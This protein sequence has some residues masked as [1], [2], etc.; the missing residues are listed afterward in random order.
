MSKQIVTSTSFSL[1]DDS[2]LNREYD[3][4]A[5][6]SE[7]QY[8]SLIPDEMEE[9]ILRVLNNLESGGK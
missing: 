4:Y 5:I 3:V 1:V 2:Y 6:A 7:M 8:M 9:D